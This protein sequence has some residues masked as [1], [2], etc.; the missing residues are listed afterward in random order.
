MLLRTGTKNLLWRRKGI[1]LKK[2]PDLLDFRA[3]KITAVGKAKADKK[4]TNELMGSRK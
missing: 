3:L 2:S 4:R 1:N